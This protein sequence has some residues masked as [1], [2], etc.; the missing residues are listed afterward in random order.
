M[1]ISYKKLRLLAVIY[2]I[3]PIIIFYIGWFNPVSALIFSAAA[4]AG[5]FFFT[6]NPDEGEYSFVYISGKKIIA[7]AIIALLWC[8]IGGQGGFVYQS[9]DHI[10]RNAILQDMIKYPWPVIY[11]GDQLLSY[12]IAQWMV[13]ACFGKAVLALTGSIS[14]AF[15]T[16]RIALLI[17]SSTGIFIALLLVSVITS[18]NEKANI[19]LSSVMFILFSGL[20]IV[21]MIIFNGTGSS[22]HLEWWAGD[23]FAQFSS[24]TTCL[25]WVYNQFI[26]SL[27][28]T[29]CII[30]EKRPS[31]FAFLGIL[32]LPYGPFPFI[33]I[34]MI[35][36]IKAV[37]FLTGQYR[38]N[39]LFGGIKAVFSLQNIISLFAVG[40]PFG[41]YY[42]SNSIISND[43]NR[44]GENINTGLRLHDGLSE[45]IS[46][47][48]FADAFLFGGKYLLF[49]LLEAG[50]FFIIIM[51]YHKKNH[52]RDI[53][54]ILSSATLIF[55]PL[56][57]IG[58]AFDFGMRVSIPAIIYIGIEF[59]RF[60]DAEL[61]KKG[62]FKDFRK[63]MNTD[64]MLILAMLAFCIGAFT[65]LNEFG[66]I[67]MG[68]IY[69][70]TGGEYEQIDSLNDQE[71]V[72]NF[73][74]PG[75]KESLFYEF[76]LKK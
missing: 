10:I 40:L 45:Y 59:I 17:W 31:N 47:G 68:T 56:F 2:A 67:F 4:A 70:G 64:P 51:L 60:A 3:L 30:N 44:N 54:F 55:I 48:K 22:L 8:F 13:P 65:S 61:P 18:S 23:N 37:V 69:Y 49:L 12:Y 25:F 34:V 62:F 5:F 7:V 24:F 9:S 63:I 29:L 76:L 75:Y 20:D 11:D 26:V 33:G 58:T 28:I 36:I 38:E 52:R 19:F 39:T 1:K 15:M 32:T 42:M 71:K 74:S 53:T 46:Q 6:R 41:L 57:Q 27:L 14:A 73:L 50:I 21:G 35:C 66:R 72:E 16:G 43:V